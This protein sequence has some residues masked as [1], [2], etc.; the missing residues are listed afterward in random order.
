MRQKQARDVWSASR[1]GNTQITKPINS[2]VV[3]LSL[4]SRPILRHTMCNDTIQ[5]L[6]EL[7]L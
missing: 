1:H 7:L 2:V 5:A 3:T 4:Y 6:Q